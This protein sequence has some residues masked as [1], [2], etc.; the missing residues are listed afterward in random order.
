MAILFFKFN[1][2]SMGT[3]KKNL[4]LL[5]WK[6][7]MWPISLPCPNMRQWVSQWVTHLGIEL[8]SQL[9][10]VKGLVIHWGY[11]VQPKNG[12]YII[13]W[14]FPIFVFWSYLLQFKFFQAKEHKYPCVFRSLSFYILMF[15][16]MWLQKVLSQEI[17]M[18]YSCFLTRKNLNGRRNN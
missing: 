9:K 16:H 17:R 8:F 1:G 11:T 7:N 13:K 12:E 15:F 4:K 3:T 18:E 14:F 6:S 10:T 5:A 2:M